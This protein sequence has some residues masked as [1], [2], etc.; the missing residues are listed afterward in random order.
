MVTPNRDEKADLNGNTELH[1]DPEFDIFRACYPF[2]RQRAAE[3]FGMEQV[4]A[5]FGGGS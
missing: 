1:A 2:A 3:M 5:M 4:V